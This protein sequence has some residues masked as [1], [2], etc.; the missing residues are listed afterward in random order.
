MY[1]LSKAVQYL[2]R[3]QNGIIFDNCTEPATFFLPSPSSFELQKWILDLKS[4]V[5][6]SKE[7]YKKKRTQLF[8][9]CSQMKFHEVPPLI[10]QYSK[11]AISFDLADIIKFLLDFLFQTKHLKELNDNAKSNEDLL[12]VF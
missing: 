4:G 9:N 11:N 10:Y 1:E 5:T 7:N 6:V 2:S 3:T 8:P 12:F